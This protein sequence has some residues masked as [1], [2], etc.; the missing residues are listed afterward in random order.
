MTYTS[1][2]TTTTNNDNSNINI[3]IDD[4]S[5]INRHFEQ[6]SF[7]QFQLE[8]DYVPEASRLGN[9]RFRTCAVLVRKTPGSRF[10]TEA[11]QHRS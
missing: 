10:R 5:N 8:V 2:Y 3:I 7:G 11:S 4:Y 9:G 1:I 6:M